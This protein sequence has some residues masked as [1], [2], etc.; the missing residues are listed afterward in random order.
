MGCKGGIVMQKTNVFKK[1]LGFRV[2]V[3]FG[4]TDLVLYNT[5]LLNRRSLRFEHMHSFFELHLILKGD[6]ILVIDGERFS[7]KEGQLCWINPNCRRHVE[8]YP[9]TEHEHF[10]LH[11]DFIQRKNNESY[12]LLE[13]EDMSKFMSQ[14]YRNK[15][16]IFDDTHSCMKIYEMIQKELE[17]EEFAYLANTKNLLCSFLINAIRSMG[18]QRDAVH[19]QSGQH[20]PELAYKALSYI[21]NH[22]QEGLTIEET[23]KALNISSRHLTRLLKET[24]GTTFNIALLSIQ[25]ANVEE[26]LLTTDDSLERIA[27]LTGF[28]SAAVMCANFKKMTGYTVSQYR[29][30]PQ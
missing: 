5:V 23:A 9:K 2:S 22:F 12:N 13:Y 18:I 29:S 7:A 19:T 24:F 28:S 27:E 30:T 21:R 11:F 25:I 10:V 4:P 17:S 14:I 1:L 8:I 20:G 3:P 15:I 16:W 26:M 6:G